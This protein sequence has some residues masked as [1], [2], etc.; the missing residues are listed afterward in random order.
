MLVKIIYFH[1]QNETRTN[2]SITGV[3]FIHTTQQ[4]SVWLTRIQNEVF[5]IGLRPLRRN[6]MAVSETFRITK[7]PIP[8]MV[9]MSQKPI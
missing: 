4:E 9:K 6:L 7:D 8:L 3:T 5:Y 2:H 1:K